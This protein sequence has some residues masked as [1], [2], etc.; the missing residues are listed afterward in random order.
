MK[1]TVCL[2]S[3]VLPLLLMGVLSRPN[4]HVVVS[5]LSEIQGGGF[6]LSAST[7]GTH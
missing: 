2:D 3:V 1:Q 7:S 6:L 4:K 5:A